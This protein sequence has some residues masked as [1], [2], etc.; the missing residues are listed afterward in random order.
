MAMTMPSPRKIL[1]LSWATLI[2]STPTT[3]QPPIPYIHGE[4]IGN[5]P[6]NPKCGPNYWCK[7]TPPNE[8]SGQNSLVLAGICE[9]FPPSCTQMEHHV[10]SMVAATAVGTAKSLFR[11]LQN[12]IP[13]MLG[14]VVQARQVVRGSIQCVIDVERVYQLQIHW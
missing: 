2:T 14:F 5:N 13:Q 11:T 6:D 9:E 7:P 4:S 10:T 1:V 3:V 12:V 8:I